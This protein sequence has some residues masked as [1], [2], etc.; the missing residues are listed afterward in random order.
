ML[1]DKFIRA[2]IN[3]KINENGVEFKSHIDGSKHLFTPEYAIEIQNSIGANIIMALI[4]MK[5]EQK[6]KYLL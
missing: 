5:N 4:L 2:A 3:R 6:Q 1:S